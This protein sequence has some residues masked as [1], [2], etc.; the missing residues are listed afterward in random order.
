MT[1][2]APA[3]TPLLAIFSKA[4]LF[5]RS[6]DIFKFDSF[7]PKSAL[8]WPGW[9]SGESPLLT[10]KAPMCFWRHSAFISWLCSEWLNTSLT[11]CQFLPEDFCAAKAIFGESAVEYPSCLH[12]GVD[13]HL[14]PMLARVEMNPQRQPCVFWHSSLSR[15][16]L[17]T[18][19]NQAPTL[20]IQAAA[21][22]D[23]DEEDESPVNY[24][25]LN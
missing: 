1:E 10:F 13:E 24:P 2:T 11:Q 19:P 22:A 17:H 5:G 9:S 15:L 7:T 18:S 23:D 4:L 21:A 8:R 20:S 6:C 14:A 25:L 12:K 16:Y 3:H